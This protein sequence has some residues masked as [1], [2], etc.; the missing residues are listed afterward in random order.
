MAALA[1]LLA[2]LAAP[3]AAPA[4]NL[5][6]TLAAGIPGA[7]TPTTST[8]F[9]V[10]N[11]NVAVTSLTGG[12]SAEAATAGGNSFFGG[13][14]TPVL[15]NLDNGSAY[16]ASGGASP[17]ARSGGAGGGTRSSVAPVAGGTVPTDTALLGIDLAEPTAPG[18]SRSL[19][20]KFTDSQGNT[21]GSGSVNVPDGGWWVIGLGPDTRTVP[22]PVPDPGPIDPPPPVDPIPQPPVPTPPPGPTTGGVATPEP[23]TLA[24]AALGG[25]TVYAWRRGRM[26]SA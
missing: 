5:W 4:A 13:V 22:D 9:T 10:G 23:G 20:A 24:L 12:I 18:G 6:V 15:L 16:I 1:T 19:T 8:D 21:I 26:R 25:S 17:A 2:W 11:S 7:D 14:G 3:A